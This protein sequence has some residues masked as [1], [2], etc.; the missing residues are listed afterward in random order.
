MDGLNGTDGIDAYPG[1]ARGLF[2]ETAEYRAM[3]VVSLNG[4]EWR[5]KR[6]NPGPLPGDGWMLSAGRGKRGEKGESGIGRSGRD[7]TS[8]VALYTDGTSIIATDSAGGEFRADME[9]LINAALAAR[10]L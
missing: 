3:D 8:L 5:A 7:G 10:G 1:A 9:S 2:D 6:D 4:S